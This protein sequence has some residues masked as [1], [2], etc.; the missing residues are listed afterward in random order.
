MRLN[1]LSMLVVTVAVLVPPVAVRTAEGVTVSTSQQ[2]YAPGDEVT[3]VIDNN[4]GQA[5]FVP[6]CHPFEVEEFR[7]DN[8]LR[9]TR[10]PCRWEGTSTSLGPG[11][12]ELP[13]ATKEEDANRIYRVSMTY[14][15]SCAEGKALSRSGCAEFSSVVSATFRVGGKK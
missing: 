8:Y 11:Q 13:W 2:A 1:R 15:W 3:V 6:G 9:V 5:I 4:T 12:H 7:E 14:G 10:E